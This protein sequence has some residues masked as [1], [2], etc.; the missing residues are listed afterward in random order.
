MM[1]ETLNVILAM[2]AFGVLH[3][4]TA[5]IG[6]KALF[7]SIMGQRGYLGLY[8]LFYNTLSVITFLPV[9]AL[10][11]AQP[12]ETLW[13]FDGILAGVLVALQFLGLLGLLISLLQID[14]MAFLG[15]KQAM[16]YFSGGKLPLDPEPLAVGGVY[17]LVRHPLYLFSLMFLWFSPIMTA[18]YLGL[19]IGSTL[20]FA[21]GS[22][23]EEQ[24]L[25][26]YFG[27]AYRRYQRE[28]AWLIPY[29]KK[30]L[31]KSESPQSE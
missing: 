10:V 28:V 31:S 25:A 24:K 23:L 26:K 29:P 14:G 21:L 15:I 4:L 17:A 1:Q 13:S 9:L 8:R 27:E 18:A 19:C 16:V 22:L 11:A 3:S 6:V 30:W 5:A 12:G 7:V 2:V 20:Y